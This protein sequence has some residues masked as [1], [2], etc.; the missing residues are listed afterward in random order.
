MSTCQ[1]NFL[2]D[3]NILKMECLCMFV[4]VLLPKMSS[5]ITFRLIEENLSLQGRS[6]LLLM[7]SPNLKVPASRVVGEGP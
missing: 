7:A 1:V 6:C 5:L 4:G 2:K 3:M